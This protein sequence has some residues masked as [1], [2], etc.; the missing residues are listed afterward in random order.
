[1]LITVLFGS[2]SILQQ[3]AKNLQ[4][5]FLAREIL[6]YINMIR[7]SNLP[8]LKFLLVLTCRQH[9]CTLINFDLDLRLKRTTPMWGC[10][11]SNCCHWFHQLIM[12]GKVWKSLIIVESINLY[13]VL[14][15]LV[16]LAQGLQTYYLW[17]RI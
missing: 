11:W 9:L 2:L 16:A 1:M 13:N 7:S 4:K 15:N 6:V 17:L 10:Y 8:Q 5:N 3:M 12:P 14:W